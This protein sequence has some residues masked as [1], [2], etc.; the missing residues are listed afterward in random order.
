MFFRAI[1]IPDYPDIFYSHHKQNQNHQFQNILTVYVEKS[2]GHR[3][4]IADC[5]MDQDAYR[6]G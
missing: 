5:Q 6:Q 2:S 4:D 1:G 3:G